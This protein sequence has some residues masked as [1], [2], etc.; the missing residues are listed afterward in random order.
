MKTKYIFYKEKRD[1]YYLVQLFPTKNLHTY[2]EFD[3]LKSR[4]SLFLRGEFVGT[5]LK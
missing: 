3:Q 5:Y 1:L 4:K 2:I